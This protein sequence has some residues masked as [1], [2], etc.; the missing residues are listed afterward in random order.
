[1]RFLKRLSLGVVSVLLASIAR[2]DI[3]DADFAGDRAKVEAIFA[4][5]DR[6]QPGF[7]EYMA[8][9]ADDILL[10]PNGGKTVEGKA[11]YRQHVQDFY[12]SGSIQIRHEAIAIQSY[13]DVAIV[14][15]RAVGTF[16]PTG[17]GASS[18]FETRNLFVFRR[19]AGGKLM[20]SHI[21][22]NYP[23]PGS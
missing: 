20:V 15:G 8:A 21:I 18:S 14:Q 3:S 10:I 11:A 12:A 9:V 4:A 13:R 17:G 16:T 5:H 1:M 22:F 19:A 23:P 7:D 2:P 6:L